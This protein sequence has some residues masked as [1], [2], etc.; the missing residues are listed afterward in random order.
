MK[1]KNYLI[2]L[3]WILISQL[4]IN[5]IVFLKF[6][7]NLPRFISNLILFKKK[8]KGKIEIIPCLHDWSE[9]G[10]TTKDEYFLQDLMYR[11]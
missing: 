5:I 1:F 6:F 11:Q 10:G 3:N 9:E 7:I 8:Y 2:R 4:G